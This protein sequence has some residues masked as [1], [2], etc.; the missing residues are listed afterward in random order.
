MP[1]VEKQSPAIQQW[2]KQ[3]AN[4][5][6]TSTWDLCIPCFNLVENKPAPKLKPYNDEPDDPAA[7]VVDTQSGVDVSDEDYCCELCNKKLTPKNY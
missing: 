4:G 2:Y 1:R 7:I 5:N 6:G 3:S